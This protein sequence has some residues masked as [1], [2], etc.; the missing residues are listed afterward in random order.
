MKTF[1][2]A[3]LA[4]SASAF[5]AMAVPDF[6]AGFMF[7]MT[8]DNNLSEIEAC[9]QGGDKIVT[10]SQIALSDFRSGKYFQGIKDAGIVW[11][12]VGAAM[13]TCTGMQRDIREIENWA[14]IFTQPATL[15]KTVA[16]NWLFHGRKIRKDI[17]QEEADWSAG[18]YFDAGKDTA[19]ALMLAVGPMQPELYQ[20]SVSLPD[21]KGPV[22][23]L[24]GVLDGL[25]GENH[26]D[27]IQTCATDAESL[28]P[29]I[30]ELISDIEAKHMIKGARLAKKIASEIPTMLSACEHMGPQLKAL[31]EWATVLE[32]PKNAA[33]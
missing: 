20:T 13:T 21:V 28:V 27:Q 16:K 3:C 4:A 12:E 26:L 24:A 10:D 17:D 6:V 14:T 18:N 19:E 32:H 31:G 15:S 33:E 25:V 11:N 7:A 9:Y 1:A 8:G 2:A 23:F 22:E 29:E 30:E 5:D